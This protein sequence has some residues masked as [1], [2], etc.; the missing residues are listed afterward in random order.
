MPNCDHRRT[1]FVCRC[2]RRGLGH[3]GPIQD[4]ARQSYRSAKMALLSPRRPR[5]TIPT[6]ATTTHRSSWPSSSMPCY[7]MPCDRRARPPRRP[8]LSSRTGLVLTG[9]TARRVPSSSAPLRYLAAGESNRVGVW[10]AEVQCRLLH[11]NPFCR[12]RTPLDSLVPPGGCA[13]GCISASSLPWRSLRA[14]LHRIA[15]RCRLIRGHDASFLPKDMRKMH[16]SERQR[17]GRGCS[18]SRPRRAV[19]W[20]RCRS[21]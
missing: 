20:P 5:S 11:R 4:R 8:R 15:L 9:S 19:Q 16:P 13:A 7:A 18:R 10:R 3:G 21:G 1:T 17:H 12:S 14:A 6:A 2:A